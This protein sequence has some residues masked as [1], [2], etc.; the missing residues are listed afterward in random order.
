[1]VPR[2]R[3]VEE[4]ASDHRG[5]FE[6]A[7]V[8]DLPVPV[9]RTCSHSTFSE[10]HSRVATLIAPGSVRLASRRQGPGSGRPPPS[11]GRR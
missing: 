5:Q 10:L 1:M 7:R 9:G 11:E 8:V 3:P 4:A 2:L 6:W